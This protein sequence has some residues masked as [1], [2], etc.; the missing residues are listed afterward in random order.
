[1]PLSPSRMAALVVA[2]CFAAGLNVYATVAAQGALGR[3]LAIDLPLYWAAAMAAA[4]L[5][6]IHLPLGVRVPAIAADPR[7]SPE[8]DRARACGRF[9]FQRSTAAVRR[10]TV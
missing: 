2:T 3:T 5:G 4:L 8:S 1:M 10:R 9:R 7:R 6:I